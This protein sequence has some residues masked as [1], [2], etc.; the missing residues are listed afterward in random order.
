MTTEEKKE[1]L[2]RLRA[3][4]GAQR[5]IVTKNMSKVTDIVEDEAFTFSSSEQVHKAEVISRLLEAKLKTIEDVDHEVLSLCNVDEIPQEIE[6]SERHVEK[7]I[8]CQ[9]EISDVSQPAAGVTQEPPNPLAG[10]IQ[11]LPGGVSPSV[12]SQIKAKQ[13]KL[14]LPKFRGD[15]TTWMGFW[16][17]YKSA[18]HDNVSLSKIDKIQ[19]FEIAIGRCRQPSHSRS[20]FI[21]RQLWT[22]ISGVEILEQRFGKI[23]QIISAYMGEI[24]K[25]QPRLTDRPSSL[26][27]LYDKLSVHVG[28]L[29]SLGVSSQEYGS[30][31]I[32]IIMSKL[33]N[34]IRLE[35]VLKST[36]EVWKID[37]LLDT[38]K[39]EVEAREASEAVKTQEVPLRKPP[40]PGSNSSQSIPI[41]NKLFTAESKE[42]QF[43]C[44]YYNGE[45]YSASSTDTDV[46]Q[47]KERGD[48]LQRNDQCFIC[49]KTGHDAKN[50]FKTKR[51]RHCDE[52]HH[53]S[54]STRI[55]KP[56][57]EQRR[58]NGNGIPRG[59]P[60]EYVTVSTT[61]TAKS[62]TKA[63]VLV[64]TASCMAVNGS[65]SIAVR[66]LFDNGSQRSYVSSIDLH[67]N[68]FGDT[69]YRKRKCNVVK[70]CLQ[71]PEIMR[72]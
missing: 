22:T 36:N 14:V 2:T 27:F 54:I 68:T 35:I 71:K 45:H 62:T 59:K 4:R 42:F 61:T 72:K 49:L 63:I 15:V 64:K 30:L 8:T 17:S 37:E 29:S 56:T 19:L 26:R 69:S 33:P 11:A 50:C 25:L 43:R 9:K 51:C 41:A 18:M 21:K 40:N 1:R 6:G 60:N 57:E 46:Q 44:V 31:L 52:K 53:Q 66:V 13:A 12:P 32:P 28:G 65:N 48:I 10:L 70:L 16:D 58:P 5:A 24:L 67:I 20:C 38:I 7:V 55:D 23:Q 34:E 39:G 47:T 3:I